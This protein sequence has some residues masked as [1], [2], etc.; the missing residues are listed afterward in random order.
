MEVRKTVVPCNKKGEEISGAK[1]R[2]YIFFKVKFNSFRD[3]SHSSENAVLDKEELDRVGETAG[4]LL[5]T[6]GLYAEKI[7]GVLDAHFYNLGSAA[8]AGAAYVL[9]SLQEKRKK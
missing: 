7:R 5:S 9:K 1:V 3:V 2:E 8:K 6:P 4:Q